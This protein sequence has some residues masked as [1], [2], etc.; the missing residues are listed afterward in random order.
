MK[1]YCIVRTLKEGSMDKYIKDHK[2]IH[3][4][5]YKEILK[6]IKDSGVKEEV[7]FVYKNSIIL[8]FEAED[9]DKSYEL[10]AGA[11]VVKKWDEIMGPLF[12][13]LPDSEGSK[14]L[15]ESSL[16]KVFDLNEQIEGKLNP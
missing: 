12:E 6:V 8:Y 16:P 13:T 1:K 10:Q 7:I 9:L 3:E 2:E 4:G 14:T 5:P 15:A 11:E